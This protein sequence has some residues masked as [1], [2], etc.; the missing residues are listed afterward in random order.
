MRRHYRWSDNQKRWGPWIYSCESYERWAVELSSDNEDEEVCTFRVSA[1]KHTLILV[2]PPWLKPMEIKVDYRATVHP[3]GPMV[4]RSYID[5]VRRQ[6]GFSLTNDGVWFLQLFW[7][8]QEDC[9][10]S[11][12]GKHWSCF[13]PWSDHR[14]VRHTF[15][16]LEAEPLMPG[17]G[18]GACPKMLFDFLDFDGEPNVVSTCIEEREWRRGTGWFKWLSRFSKPRIRRD[19]DLA[20]E[21]ETGKRKGSW[22]GGTVGHSIDMLPGELHEGAFKRYCV[23][24]NMTYIGRHYERRDV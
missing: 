8:P 15:Y 9:W 12:Y 2:M 16:D 11:K 18:R 24:H 13:L 14:F 5:R 6:Y 10:P 22:K 23:E 1:G 21:K 20:F 3:D 4:D 17:S 7:G 19:L